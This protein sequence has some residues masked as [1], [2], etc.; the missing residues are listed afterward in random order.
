ME[1]HLC[2]APIRW[3]YTCLAFK[4]TTFEC[5]VEFETRDLPHQQKFFKR[6]RTQCHFF[7][8]VS[9]LMGTNTINVAESN[10]HE[11]GYEMSAL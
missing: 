9:D 2:I 3:N 11:S 8:Y 4:T 5:Q 10:Y 1:G 7:P 6:A